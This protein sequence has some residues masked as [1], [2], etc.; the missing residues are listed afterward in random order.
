MQQRRFAHLEPSISGCL[1]GRKQIIVDRIG[2]YR[3]GA[4]DN[5]AVDMDPEIHTQDIVVLQNDLL[6][7]RI[8]SPVSSHVVQAETGRKTH[9]GFENISGLKALVIGQRPNAIFNFLSKLAHGDAGL[10]DRLHML[11][12]LAMNLR[13]FAIVA[14]ELITHVVQDG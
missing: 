5:P 13:S 11:P 8:G 4:I 12:N 14:Q 7:S 10:C 2:N 1:D 3:E 6:G 9:A